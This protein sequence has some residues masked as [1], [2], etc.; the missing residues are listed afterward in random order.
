MGL[1]KA[2]NISGGFAKKSLAIAVATS[3]LSPV[4]LSQQLEEIIVTAQKREQ[5]IND[6][7]ITMNVFTTD[8]LDNFG[9]NSAED[10]ERLVP[11]LTVSNAQPAGAPVYTIRGVGFNDFTTAASS[12]VG[13]YNDG[14]SLPYPVMTRSA[15]YDIERIEVLKGPQGDLYGRNTTAG[16]INFIA[17]KPTKETEAGIN[18]DYG[19]FETVDVEAY[20]SGSL[21]ESV[22]ARLAIKSVNS[23]E[24]WQESIT[25][26][27]DILGER[28]ELAMRL[29]VNFD[30]NE[31]ASL[32]LKL[33]RFD[34]DSDNIAGTPTSIFGVPVTTQFDNQDADW[35]ADFRPGNDNTLEG[36]S[37]TLQW[38]LGAVSLTSISSYDQYERLATFDTSAIPQT[39]ADATNNSNI[40]VFSQE[41]RLESNNEEG[42]YWTA[43]LFY[44]DDEVD[45]SYEL[46]FSETQSLHLI[47]RYQ[48]QNESMA[49]FGRVEWQLNEQ[50]RLSLGARYTEEERDFSACTFDVGNGLLAGFYNFFV[51]PMFFQ[52]RG[53]TPS[54]LVPGDCAV[55]N[56]LAGTDGFGDF[57]PFAD[58]ID[59]DKL[60]GKITLDYSPSDNMLVYGTLSTGFKSGGFNGAGALVHSQLQAYTQEELTSF[61]IGVKSTLL[62]QSMQLNASAFLYDYQ[63]KQ[64]LTNFISPIGDVVGITNVPESKVQGIEVEL[65]WAFSEGWLLN[66]G[67]TYLDTEIEE[68]IANCPAGLF[69]PPDPASLPTGCP[70]A[71]TFDNILTFDASGANLDNAP[72]LQFAGSLSYSWALTDNLNM[73]VGA[74]VSHKDDNVGSQ[75]APTADSLNFLPDYTLI[76][77]RIGISDAAGKWGASIWG[78][79][80]TDEYYWHSTSSSNS[81]TIQLNGL[82]AT[83]GISLSYNFL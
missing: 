47:N 79:N 26:P 83:Y 80:I 52:P 27:D 9:I 3:L 67:A 71:S 57:G 24:G 1:E 8:Q 50:Y 81:T 56:D 37:A 46:D 48:Q 31:D 65:S 13:L 38:D 19:R 15:L 10:L 22:Q 45:E 33:H 70:A 7:G 68:F 20:V 2:I 18:L 82:P 72:E 59:T 60:M 75:A 39:D 64:E 51:T 76:N 63:N 69:F 43:G 12:T 73:M 55:F 4:V 30:I 25:R 58:S 66:F 77:A 23:G 11:G 62:N 21:S 14:A 36:V 53:F 5:S 78:R 35:T 61:E 41:I 44:S 49:V 28:D 6:V 34:N 42:F 40:D 32:L 16:Q 17:N 29:T 74:D 54:T